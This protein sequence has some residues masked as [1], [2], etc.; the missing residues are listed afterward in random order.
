MSIVPGE[1]VAC[2]AFVIL[3][4]KEN[5]KLYNSEVVVYFWLQRLCERLYL[6]K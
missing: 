5:D 1:N 3:F 2:G 4:L 6:I